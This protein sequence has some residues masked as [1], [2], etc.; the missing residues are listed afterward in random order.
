LSLLSILLKSILYK[1]RSYQNEN[2]RLQGF[3]NDHKSISEDLTKLK[4]LQY[5][6]KHEHENISTAIASADHDLSNAILE[7]NDLEQSIEMLEKEEA[8]M[9]EQIEIYKSEIKLMELEMDQ[10]E[11]Q[12]KVDPKEV[13]ES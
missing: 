8:R 4:Q 2:N 12:F 1:I 10:H 7:R 11:F 3:V 6:F 5:E 9:N 13:N